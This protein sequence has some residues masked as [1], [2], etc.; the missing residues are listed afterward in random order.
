MPSF[1]TPKSSTTTAKTTSTPTLST[2]KQ[3]AK[4]FKIAKRPAPIGKAKP[5]AA[6]PKKQKK[7][8]PTPSQLCHIDKLHG[9]F[10]RCQRYMRQIKDTITV[11]DVLAMQAHFDPD[12]QVATAEEWKEHA[13][14]VVTNAADMRLSMQGCKWA[15]A[16]MHHL[17]N[18]GLMQTKEILSTCNKQTLTE[19]IVRVVQK[20]T[21]NSN[22]RVT[23]MQQQ[24]D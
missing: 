23:D 15:Q 4:P 11:D 8:Q 24:F 21:E 3:I 1:K 16:L 12:Y 18:D 6:Q 7:Q 5:K 13:S 9:Q 17:V 22:V 10:T 14:Q 19:D 20:N 2:K